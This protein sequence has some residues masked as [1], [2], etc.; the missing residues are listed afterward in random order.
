MYKKYSERGQSTFIHKESRDMKTYRHLANH[1]D[2][3][4]N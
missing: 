1:S 2:I 3:F 4:Y